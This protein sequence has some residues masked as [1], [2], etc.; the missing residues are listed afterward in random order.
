MQL[1]KAVHLIRV[2][3]CNVLHPGKAGSLVDCHDLEC[4]EV[5]CGLGEIVVEAWGR[6]KY[7]DRPAVFHF[8]RWQSVHLKKAARTRRSGTLELSRY[9]KA[10]EVLSVTVVPL[11]VTT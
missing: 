7:E 2:H 5:S 11:T 3:G 10:T 9:E 6:S 1:D 8:I 4:I